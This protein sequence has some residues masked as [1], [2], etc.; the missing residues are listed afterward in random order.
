MKLLLTGS[1]YGREARWNLKTLV[2][3]PVI[4]VACWTE[5][6]WSVDPL[7]RCG[8]TLNTEAYPALFDVEELVSGTYGYGSI[9]AD[10]DVIQAEPP[11]CNLFIGPE[12]CA[13]CPSSHPYEAWG[14]APY[15]CYNREYYCP[16]TY[17]RTS[18]YTCKITSDCRCAHD[19]L[20]NEV[21]GY[22]SC[23]RPKLKTC[24]DGTIVAADGGICP[25]KTQQGPA[26]CVGNPI[27]F[28]SGDKIQTELDF[29]SGGDFPLLVSRTYSSRQS[30][31]GTNWRFSFTPGGYKTLE[32]PVY[33]TYPPPEH[34]P[35]IVRS[36]DGSV[37]EYRTVDGQIYTTDS[38]VLA[39]LEKTLSGWKFTAENGR[40]WDYS[41]DGRLRSIREIGGLSHYYSWSSDELKV[42]NDFGH[43]LRV[44]QRPEGASRVVLPDG[45]E[46]LYAYNAEGLLESVTYADGTMRLY[47]YEAELGQLTGITNERGV[48]YASF[49]YT[50]S[51]ATATEHAGGVNRHE[52]IYSNTS[53]LV[54]VTNPLGKSF[55]YRF[56][57]NHGARKIKST[58]RQP[59]PNC[60]SS[61]ASYTYDDHGFVI[62]EHHYNNR[63]SYFERNARG[64]IT[65][66]NESDLR[67]A[68]IQW[69]QHFPLPEVVTEARTETRYTFDPYENPNYSKKSI[70]D[71][72]TG[73]IREW[74]YTYNNLGQVLSIDG[75][76]DD[77]SDLTLLSYHDCVSGAECGQIHTI[78][79]PLG[80]VITYESYSANAQATRVIDANGVVTELAYDDRQ[81]LITVS[82]AG[83]LSTYEYLDTGRLA[84]HELPDGSYIKH[85]YDDAERL[86]ALTNNNGERIE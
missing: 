61:S 1:S 36:D 16:P 18:E 20:P 21:A 75:P 24:S 10:I 28:A 79:N 37:L 64:L 56:D 57:T 72:E 62:Q 45:G 83:Q 40:I 22:L 81:R 39:R 3:C 34:Y 70:M 73:E 49:E 41:A 59:S 78:T 17:E 66:I 38:D 30:V 52:V 68:N 23:D 25:A 60:P 13:Y 32:F 84:R 8:T 76:R 35:V 67:F 46:L 26:T 19:G 14:G 86:I 11:D 2:L 50:G 77:L 44:F 42:T 48:R 7:P 80:H 55:T 12:Y 69:H 63:N 15:R 33:L 54:S 31:A 65:Q 71:L 51:R 53:D 4:L 5:T 9:L 74:R 29:K 43:T 6:V 47:H 27:D 58:T 85:E 82:V